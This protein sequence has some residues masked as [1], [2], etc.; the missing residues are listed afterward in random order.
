M[1]PIV[2]I[3]GVILI[4]MLHANQWLVNNFKK[5]KSRYYINKND[6]CMYTNILSDK[7]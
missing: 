1:I 3:M 2:V 5:D 4:I 6:Y 7:L